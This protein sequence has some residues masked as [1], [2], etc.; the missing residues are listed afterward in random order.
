MA[1]LHS[2]KKGKS[3][4]TRPPRL[5]KPVWV[6]RSAEEVENLVVKLARR[7]FSKSMI[8]IIL[9][10]SYGIPIVKVVTGRKINEILEENEI[11]YPLPEDLTNLVKKALNIRK[12]LETNKKDLEAKKG[13]QRTESK[14]FRLIRHYKDS[15]ILP[16]DFRY[17]PDKIRTLVAR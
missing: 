6:E 4:S 14:I 3:G 2:R 15:K 1:R 8:G 17:Q 12:H 16:A 7:G 9:R 13:L 11:E 5:E 10:D